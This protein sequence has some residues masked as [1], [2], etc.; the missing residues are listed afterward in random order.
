MGA[1]L[2]RMLELANDA[3]AT[4]EATLRGMSEDQ[5]RFSPGGGRWSAAMIAD[6]IT[7]SNAHYLP[8]F[9]AA[10]ASAPKS[11]RPLPN[12]SFFEALF[13]RGLSPGSKMRLPVPPGLEPEPPADPKAA[14][15]GFFASHDALTDAIRRS[16]GLDIGNLRVK[17]AVGDAIKFRIPAALEALIQHERYH[18]EQ[19]KAL[20]EEAGF[21]A[22]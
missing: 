14:V 12:H 7:R 13:I 8:Q 16:R 22:R 3:R 2:D 18:L 1:S 10:L 6:H 9:D 17:S 15:A 20:I 4:A 21:P 5:L 11:D 19:V